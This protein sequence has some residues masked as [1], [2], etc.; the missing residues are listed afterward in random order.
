MKY[1]FVSL[2]ILMDY[3]GFADDLPRGYYPTEE[4]VEIQKYD[5]GI[6]PVNTPFD[7]HNFNCG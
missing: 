3:P 4:V 7:L 2:M 5:C 1:L 6:Y